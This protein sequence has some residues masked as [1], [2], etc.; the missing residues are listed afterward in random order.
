MEEFCRLF[1]PVRGSEQPHDLKCIPPYCNWAY[2]AGLPR[3]SAS[4]GSYVEHQWLNTVSDNEVLL[5]S[6][7]GTAGSGHSWL[8]PHKKGNASS[9]PILHSVYQWMLVP[10]AECGLEKVR[11]CFPFWDSQKGSPFLMAL[12][13]CRYFSC[14][15]DRIPDGSKKEG[16]FITIIIIILLFG[17]F[18]QCFS[19]LPWLS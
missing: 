10:K 3:T 2:S 5:L 8:E 15:C 13:L 19:V 12:S 6:C 11:F 18:S 9:I 17:F 16:K 14:C 7:D 1:K 4:A